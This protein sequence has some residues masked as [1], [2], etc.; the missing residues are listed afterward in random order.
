M[1]RPAVGVIVLLV[2]LCG[3][4]EALG[5]SA[6][7]S[8]EKKIAFG[9]TTLNLLRDKGV[10]TPAEY[11]SALRDLGEPVGAKAGESLSL[12]LSKW[13]ATLYGFAETDLIYDTTQS[14][15]EVS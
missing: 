13:S 11:E 8:P 3:G 12:M 1:S 6:A 7:P 9:F 14:L 15:N 4:R 5:Q 10:I 2:A